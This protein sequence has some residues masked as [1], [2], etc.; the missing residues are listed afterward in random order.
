LIN[1]NSDSLVKTKRS[2]LSNEAPKPLNDCGARPLDRCQHVRDAST[3]GPL[4]NGLRVIMTGRA[5]FL[6][7]M[8]DSFS[9]I[10][11]LS[12]SKAAFDVGWSDYLV[13]RQPAA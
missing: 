13:F 9:T 3:P 7:F 11:A 5:F 6:Q 12:L 10:T 2:G 8:S 4:R 1:R